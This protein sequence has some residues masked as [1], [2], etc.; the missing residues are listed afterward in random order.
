MERFLVECLAW[1]LLRAHSIKEPPVPVRE[2]IQHAL[3]VFERLTLLEM[4]LGLYKA[5]YRSCLD[6]SRV[7]VVDPT[8]P[9]DLQREGMARELYV[10]FCRSSRAAELQWFCR[11]QPLAHGDLF[12]RCLLTP[13]P[14][15]ELAC[16]EDISVEGLA[17]RF[18]VTI[19]TMAQRLREVIRP[20]PKSGP[21]SGESLAKTMFSLEEP[22]QG[23]FLD[24]VTKMTVS[25]TRR[26]ERPTLEEVAAWLNA[27]PGLCLDIR[28]M[29]NAWKGSW[30]VYHATRLIQPSV[31]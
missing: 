14:W 15:V 29:L 23:R 18:G 26:R 31:I 19:K 4:N 30:S 21:G 27:D 2:M 16:V 12:A 17:A 3:P 11:E 25:K 1:G 10:A 24:L 20:Q 22:W 13:A 5:A 28:Y 7:I 8:A 9:H 6:G